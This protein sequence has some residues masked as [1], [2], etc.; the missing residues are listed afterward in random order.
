MTAEH[1]IDNQ[2]VV[3]SNHLKLNDFLQR[4]RTSGNAWVFLG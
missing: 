4:L 3:S 2:L 1:L